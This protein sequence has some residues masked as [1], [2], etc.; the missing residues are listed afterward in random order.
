MIGDSGTSRNGAKHYYY[1]CS[2]RKRGGDC[3]KKSVRAKAIEEEIIN[4]T[5]R[6]VLQDDMLEH[7]ADRVMEYQARDT[8]GAALIEQYQGE[9]KETET[10]ISGILRAIEAGMFTPSMKERMEELEGQK[11]ELQADIEREQIN[12]QT[13]SRDEVLFFLHQFQGGSPEDPKYCQQLVDA[14]VNSIWLYDDKIVITY[15]YSGEGGKVTLEMVSE[16]ME[17]EA[18]ECSDTASQSPPNETKSNT[19][20]ICAGVFGF[21]KEKADRL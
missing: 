9:L 3:K 14:F 13:V 2:T 1:T 4:T 5:L 7:I 10:A 15:N 21:V 16:A 20:V 8:D 19:F 11:A 6:V 17:G 12:L 18:G